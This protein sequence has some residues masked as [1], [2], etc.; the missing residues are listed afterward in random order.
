VTTCLERYLLTLFLATH[1]LPL[2]PAS[3]LRKLSMCLAGCKCQTG[4]SIPMGQG[5]TCPPNIYEGGTSMVM[6]LPYILE[7]MLFRL[8]LFYP[9]IATAVVCCILMQ[10]LCVVSQKKLKL[11]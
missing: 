4:A 6:S 9:V 10:I 8:G 7:V 1:S 5:W 3:L 11:L 2:C